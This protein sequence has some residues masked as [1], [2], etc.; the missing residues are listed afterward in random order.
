MT[1]LAAAL[2]LGAAACAGPAAPPRPSPLAPR[3]SSDTLAALWRRA[4]PFAQFTTLITHRVELWHRNQSIA[5]VPD[6]LVTR[7]RRL[8]SWKLLV[9][10]DD[11]CSDSAN[12][13]PYIAK[14]AELAPNLELRVL[15]DSLG[16]ALKAGHRTPDGRT[17]TPTLV[18]LDASFNDRGCWVER[19][20]QLQ[21]WYIHRG[22]DVDNDTYRREKLGFYDFDHGA[23]TLEE[24]VGVLEAA[25]AGTPRCGIEPRPW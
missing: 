18:V 16:Y 23:S 25:A 24:V 17:A 6:A 11:D 10:A 14:L 2:L 12:T 19:P 5:E 22:R 7:A 15:H 1:P 8:G 21:Y 3:P 4:Q 9:T 13:L 20:A